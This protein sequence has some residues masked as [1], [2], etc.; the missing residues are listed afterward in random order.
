MT[1]PYTP[2]ALLLEELVT[3]R[4]PLLAPEVL[5]AS[6]NTP[7]PPEELLVPY[8][9]AGF[10]A[11]VALPTM[12]IAPEPLAVTVVLSGRRFSGT[13]LAMT[14][15][16]VPDRVA[17]DARGALLP[18][19]RLGN[20]LTTGLIRLLYGRRLTD[21]PPF[22]AVRRLTLDGLGMSEMTYG[23][24]VEMIVKCAKRQ[25]LA[26]PRRPRRVI[27]QAEPPIGRRR[28]WCP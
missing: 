9:P 5:V 19:Q 2:V 26:G 8:T 22:K 18:H 11:P 25:R 21:L 16:A 12:A 23:W 6:P 3:P 20:S 27:R 7:R 28:L 24:T 13:Q 10:V 15:H 4:T 14:Y 1:S 17:Y